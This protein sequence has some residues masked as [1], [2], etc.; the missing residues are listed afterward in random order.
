MKPTV[1]KLEVLNA[2]CLFS[3][4]ARATFAFVFRAVTYV[5]SS[6]LILVAGRTNGVV[7]HIVGTGAYGSTSNW[8]SP[9]TEVGAAAMGAHSAAKVSMKDRASIVMMV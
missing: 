6:G 8:R 1:G 9:E 5:A 7:G 2:P 3:H 4:E